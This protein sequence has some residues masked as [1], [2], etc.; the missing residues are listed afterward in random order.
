MSITGDFPETVLLQTKLFLE[1]CKEA[2]QITLKKLYLAL[3]Q[4]F[5]TIPNSYLVSNIY[6][7]L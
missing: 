5:F 1:D 6:I 7:S 3:K 2:K 4:A